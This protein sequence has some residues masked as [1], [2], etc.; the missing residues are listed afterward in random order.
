MIW[1]RFT[2]L[3]VWR[4]ASKKKGRQLMVNSGASTGYDH[5]LIS[6]L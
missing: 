5:F 6:T 1:M 2:V 3:P 4:S